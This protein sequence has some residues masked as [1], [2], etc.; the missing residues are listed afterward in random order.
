M[1]DNIK[2]KI[3]KLREDIRANDYKYF[4]ENEQSISDYD[5]DQLMNEL[6]ELEK[7]SPSL[8]T[9]DSPTRRVGGEPMTAFNTIDHKIPMLSIDNTYSEEELREFDKRIHRLIDDD[10]YAVEYVVELKIDG[11]A[12]SLWYEN[13]TFV[14]GITRGNGVKGDDVTANIRTIKELPLRI[15][16]FNKIFNEQSPDS[17]DSKESPHLLEIR[18]EVYLPDDDFQKLNVEREENDKPLLA[19]PRNAAAGSLKLLDPR[20]TAKRRLHLFAYEIGY[21]DWSNLSTHIDTLQFIKK[22]GLPVN[23]NYKLCAT[24]EDVINVCNTWE[25][26]RRGLP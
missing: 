4:V 23:R 20:I 9:P 3:E 1:S 12:I 21:S 2:E 26:E 19:N 15:P 11:I 8:I 25:T 13:G 17:L 7:E 6:K 14:R 5:Y 18:G 22:L 10:S 16:G 24:I